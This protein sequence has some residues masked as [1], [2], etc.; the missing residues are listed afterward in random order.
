MRE[1]H[2]LIVDDEDGAPIQ[3]TFP[4]ET[5]AVNVVETLADARLALAEEIPDL[6]VLD[7]MLLF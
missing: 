5:Y 7:V 2:V 1:F 3:E 4:S 6:V